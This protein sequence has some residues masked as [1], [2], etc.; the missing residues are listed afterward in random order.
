MTH[1]LPD[2]LPEAAEA[3]ASRWCSPLADQRFDTTVEVRPAERRGIACLGVRNLRRL[4]HH[5]PSAPGW[6]MIGRLL[7]LLEVVNAGL[8]GPLTPH[9]RRAML[10]VI[11]CCW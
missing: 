9:R 4:Q 11:A 6:A 3:P 7:R 8:D 5:D 10:D 1:A 2:A